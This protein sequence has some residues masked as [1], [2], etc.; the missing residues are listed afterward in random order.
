[1]ILNCHL[2]F[3]FRTNTI[4]SHISK[5][6]NIGIGWSWWVF[7]CLIISINSSWSSCLFENFILANSYKEAWTIYRHLCESLGYDW[8]EIFSTQPIKGML[9]IVEKYLCHSFVVID[10]NVTSIDPFMCALMLFIVDSLCLT[11][12]CSFWQL[13]LQ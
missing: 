12:F 2:F 11:A 8:F 7:N 6:T 3:L 5:W 4:Y 9:A 13:Y 1:L 10:V